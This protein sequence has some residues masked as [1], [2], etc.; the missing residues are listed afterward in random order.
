M[1]SLRISIHAPL[2]ERPPVISAKP[3]GIV[4][5]IHAPLRE[6]PGPQ[7]LY[8]SLRIFQ[9]TLPCGS[10]QR[11]PPIPAKKSTFQSTL[12]CGSDTRWVTA[13]GATQAFQST[14]PCGSDE[15]RIHNPLTKKISIHAPL[16][17]RRI[18]LLT[19]QTSRYFNPRSLAGATDVTFHFSCIEQFQSTLPC[20]S[21]TPSMI[22][23]IT[24]QNFNPRSL[25]GATAE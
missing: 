12:P 21:D 6:R 18:S 25:A 10:D 23:Y 19:C 24:F 17:E 2:R 4:I 1:R 22:Y 14:L 13:N 7:A 16:R 8:L 15:S 3:L 9:S 5:S 20:G 11:I